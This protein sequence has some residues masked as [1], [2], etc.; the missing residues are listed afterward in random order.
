VENQLAMQLLLHLL[1]L[2]RF[3]YITIHIHE[4]LCDASYEYAVTIEHIKLY[5][6][7]NFPSWYT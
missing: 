1:L 5:L 7:Y 2:L 4:C 3:I 6:E